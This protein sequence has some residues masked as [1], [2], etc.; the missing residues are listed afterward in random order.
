MQPGEPTLR[1]IYKTALMAE[2]SG[3]HPRAVI[4]L[5]PQ[6]GSAGEGA[7]WKRE[8]GRGDGSGR[9]AN[10]EATLIL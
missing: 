3:L 10:L 7:E 1:K 2:A 5:A 8:R 9:K 6:R 4:L